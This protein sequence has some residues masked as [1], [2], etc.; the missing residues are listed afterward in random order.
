MGGADD[1]GGAQLGVDGV[2]VWGLTSSG[3]VAP[4][5]GRHLQLRGALG[6]APPACPTR[7]TSRRVA[8]PLGP[9]HLTCPPQTVSWPL[10]IDFTVSSCL[11]ASSRWGLCRPCTPPR[12]RQDGWPAL[13]PP[14]R[15]HPARRATPFVRRAPRHAPGGG[16]RGARGPSRPRAA[17][18]VPSAGEGF[19]CP[20]SQLG[21][22]VPNE[23]RRSAFGFASHY[24]QHRPIIINHQPIAFDF[25]RRLASTEPN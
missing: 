20:R 17:P 5:Y 21:S 8:S 11:E 19:P 4:V 14:L 9:T 6:P 16:A 22:V 13:W 2:R 3:G 15:P 24:T 12:R 23:G 18:L 25:S 7:R 1:G 10:L